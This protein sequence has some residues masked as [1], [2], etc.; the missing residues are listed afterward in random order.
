MNYVYKC[1]NCQ[2]SREVQHRAID[3]PVIVCADDGGV[4]RRVIQLVRVN[5][6]GL[7]PHMEH[8]IGPAAHDL[9]NN[10]DRN[11]DLYQAKKEL[12]NAS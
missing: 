10:A 1:G 7:P 2:Q 4:M 6:D 12:R 5:W 11:R 9:I 3:D 8:E